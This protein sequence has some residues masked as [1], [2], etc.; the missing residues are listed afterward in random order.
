[1]KKTPIVIISVLLGAGRAKKGDPIDPEAGIWFYK[2]PGDAVTKGDVIATI[3][4]GKQEA[5][6]EAVR[7]L[8]EVCPVQSEKETGRPVIYEILR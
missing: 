5:I 7:R 8:K 2:K 1:M 3:H 4:T 6:P